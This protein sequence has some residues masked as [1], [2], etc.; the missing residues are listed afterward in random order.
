M[1]K[2]LNHYEAASGNALWSTD[3][4]TMMKTSDFVISIGAAL[5]NDSPAMK[6]AFN[7][8]QERHSNFVRSLNYSL[9]PSGKKR[10]Q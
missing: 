6:Y 7:K 10:S 4:D 5:R 2:F 3:T 8:S 1:D 9:R